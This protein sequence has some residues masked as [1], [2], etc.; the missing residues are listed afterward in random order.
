MER[1]KAN[2]C[3]SLGRLGLRNLPERVTKCKLQINLFVH[4]LL[5]SS[6][7]QASR[8]IFR[9]GYLIVLTFTRRRQLASFRT[10]FTSVFHTTPTSASGTSSHGRY[11]QQYPSIFSC[12][13]SHYRSSWQYS[14]GPPNLS[15]RLAGEQ[16]LVSIPSPRN[17]RSSRKLLARISILESHLSLKRPIT[18][19]LDIDCS[20]IWNCAEWEW[21]V[22][23]YC[24]YMQT[25]NQRTKSKSIT[26]LTGYI[27]NPT[28]AL[29]SSRNRPVKNCGKHQA[30]RGWLGRCYDAVSATDIIQHRMQCNRV[31]EN[32]EYV[33]GWE[34]YVVAYCNVLRTTTTTLL[35]ETYS[36]P[37]QV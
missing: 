13:K 26:F 24:Y 8:S 25:Y 14:E 36:V 16:Q 2:C 15:R 1:I 33:R 32:Y 22:L 27:Q 3:Q 23:L 11:T 19:H 10:L 37:S 20:V 5:E 29:K 21:N 6:T 12:L 18:F 35:K 30:R 17:E 31:S 28:H 7:A 9:S 4:T 34:E